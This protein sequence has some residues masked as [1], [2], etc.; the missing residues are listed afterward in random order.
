M[1]KEFVNGILLGVIVSAIIQ[2]ILTFVIL[3]NL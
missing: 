3:I 1:K 2:S